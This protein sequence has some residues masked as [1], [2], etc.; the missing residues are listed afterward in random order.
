MG[1]TIVAGRRSPAVI[2]SALASAGLLVPIVQ[3]P[4][5]SR[6]FG[7]T[8]LGPLGWSIALG[9]ASAATGAS[10][11]APWLASLL[12]TGS[13]HAASAEPGAEA[14]GSGRDGDERW[15]PRIP[16]VVD[17]ASV[18]RPENPGLVV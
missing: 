13:S 9:S 14:S 15:S 6:F 18:Q 11:V 7:C 8:P 4:V 10:I 3:V 17:T 16:V 2:A 12:R 1:Q 5:V